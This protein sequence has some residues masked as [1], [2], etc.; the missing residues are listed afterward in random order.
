MSPRAREV[1]EKRGLQTFRKLAASDRKVLDTLIDEEIPALRSEL[2]EALQAA[3]RDAVEAR[4]L[5]PE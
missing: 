3:P 2:Y 5:Q 4:P 1:A